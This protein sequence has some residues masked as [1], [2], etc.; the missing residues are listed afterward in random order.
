[1]LYKKKNAV[2]NFFTIGF[3]PLHIIL[4][5]SIKYDLKLKVLKQNYNLLHEK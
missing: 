4:Y 3:S 5:S 2:I 1:M